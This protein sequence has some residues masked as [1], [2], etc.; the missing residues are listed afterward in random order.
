MLEQ[1]TTT[2]AF[3]ASY[4]AYGTV[5]H[6]RQMSNVVRIPSS[7]DQALFAPGPLDK[8]HVQVRKGAPGN[9]PVIISRVWV[10]DVQAA[11]QHSGIGKALQAVEAAIEHG[12]K[13][14]PDSR[15]HHSSSGS[16]LPPTIGGSRAAWAAAARA[17][18]HH[19]QINEHLEELPQPR[20][21]TMRR[22][23]DCRLCAF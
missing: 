11:A 7:N 18:L 23:H 6:V 19:P 13:L 5:L 12:G 20:D 14:K 1:E 9:G 4:Q 16:W 21:R 17:V 22:A 2:G 3:L 8:H 15:T 10:K